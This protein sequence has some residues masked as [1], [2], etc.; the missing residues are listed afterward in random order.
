M[1]YLDALIIRIAIG[2]DR[3]HYDT[4]ATTTRAAAL[5]V[6]VSGATAVTAAVIGCHCIPDGGC[7]GTQ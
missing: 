2:L 3:I 4:A 6:P 1:G 5:A 7:F